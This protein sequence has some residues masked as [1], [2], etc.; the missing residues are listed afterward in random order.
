MF[1]QEDKCSIFVGSA[2]PSPAARSM[3]KSL[4][5]GESRTLRGVSNAKMVELSLHAGKPPANLPKAVCP[6]KL[7]EE[8]RHELRPAIKA[9]GRSISPVRSNRFFKLR[10]REKTQQLAEHT[11]KLPHDGEP[12]VG[13]MLF[14]SPPFSCMRGSLRVQLFNSVSWT[15]VL[16]G[17]T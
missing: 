5:V 13:E 6:P 1:S 2:S 10:A 12:P 15:R 11:I 3:A 4:G 14:S 9:F 7:A 8:H 17:I 16:R